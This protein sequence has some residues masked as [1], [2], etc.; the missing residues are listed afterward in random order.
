M[1]PIHYAHEFGHFLPGLLL[2][3]QVKMFFRYWII[4]HSIGISVSDLFFQPTWKNLVVTFCGPFFG[5]IAAFLIFRAVKNSQFNFITTEFD[6]IWFRKF[7]ATIYLI[8]LINETTNFIPMNS[9]FYTDGAW[10]LIFLNQKETL[11]KIL[12]ITATINLLL[13]PIG[14]IFFA[15]FTGILITIT[16]EIIHRMNKKYHLPLIKKLEKIIVKEFL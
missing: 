3:L 14:P 8:E 2:G 13:S 16:S 1:L 5:T 7:L 6:R 10:I 15:S 4:P 12:Q 11:N 9:S